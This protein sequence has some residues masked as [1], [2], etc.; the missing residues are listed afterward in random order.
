MMLSAFLTALGLGYFLQVCFVPL[1]HRLTFLKS[2]AMN[3]RAGVSKLGGAAIAV[4]SVAA[5]AFVTLY[6]RS[7]NRDIQ[8]FLLALSMAFILG[9][10]DDILN[11]SPF[12]KLTLQI[13]IAVFLVL[14]GIVTQIVF[15]SASLNILISIFW[16]VIVMNAINF[17]DILDGLA[18]GISAICAATFLYISFRTANMTAGILSAALLGSNL[19][20]LRFNT[21][22]ARLYMGEMGSFLN[23]I[24]L[25][26]IAILLGYAT[27]GREFAVFVPLLILAL[28][29]L[30]L[31][32]VVFRRWRL[33]KPLTH[34]SRDHLVLCWTDAGVSWRRVIG[35]MYGFNLL[36]CFGAVLLFH[37][38]KAIS[39]AFV[40]LAIGLWVK[41]CLGCRCGQTA[42]GQQR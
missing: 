29:L 30:D 25:A 23:G 40:A 18:A 38:F 2:P 17:L 8:T 26:M 42:R 13:L 12:R 24:S 34:K 28:P 39:F 6:A 41:W 4:S 35:R 31:S 27:L 33:H 9:A 20:F 14:R 15:L 21:L 11:L 1:G 16:F 37:A 5:I 10:L 22:P 36:W 3:G 32:Y 7:L 19:A